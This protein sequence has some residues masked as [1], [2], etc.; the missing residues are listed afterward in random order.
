MDFEF[1]Q[2]ASRRAIPSG[3]I[4]AASLLFALLLLVVGFF[5]RF[6]VGSAEPTT[7]FRPFSV[8][9]TMIL[10]ERVPVRGGMARAVRVN[11]DGQAIIRTP[12]TISAA[13]YPVVRYRTIQSP[14]LEAR[15]FWR[16]A[17]EPE[18][19]FDVALPAGG[20]AVALAGQSGWKGEIAELGLIVNLIA[21]PPA[22]LSGEDRIVSF[23][24]ELTG[25]STASQAA[26]LATH[27]TAF[28]SWTGRSIN[29]LG[30]SLLP[31]ILVA[32]ILLAALLAWGLERVLKRRALGLTVVVGI[33]AS[34]LL[35]EGLW[36]HQFW[37]QLAQTRAQ[38]TAD[39]TQ[40]RLRQGEDFLLV[41]FSMKLAA[42]L[43][44]MQV[45]G[46]IF[47]IDDMRYYGERA[48][49]LLLPRKVVHLRA[50][51]KLKDA[52][53]HMGPGD[54]VVARREDLDAVSN[55]LRRRGVEFS[56]LLNNE[57]RVALQ[58]S[59]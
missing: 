3:W 52:L 43:R 9:G 13:D 39:S 32:W 40:D 22:N 55:I 56:K 16:R 36:V 53:Q 27:W 26:L 11:T 24:L 42:S 50:V 8:S 21:G 30:N 51:H 25:L 58:I 54:T 5:I 20:N 2:H 6:W 35:L 12:V 4:A 29:D 14:R 18:E 37:R 44:E 28:R 47:F 17:G 46:R 49:Y 1:E 31:A 48:K 41:E 7:P 15:L 33:T 57:R 23:A 34:W 19:I 45:A 10:G 38:Y 59:G